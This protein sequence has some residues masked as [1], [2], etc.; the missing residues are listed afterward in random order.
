F[1]FWS[2]EGTFDS[3]YSTDLDGNKIQRILRST[4]KIKTISLDFINVKLFWIQHDTIN[5]ISYFGTS[6]YNG[7]FIKLY[8]QMERSKAYDI[9]IFGDHIY[10][11]DSRTGTIRRANKYTG[12]DIVVIN[13]KQPFPQ[14]TEILVVHPLK[15]IGKRM[16]SK[17][18]GSIESSNLNGMQRKII[19]Q[20]KVFHPQGIA[21]HPFT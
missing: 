3:I 18:L 8:R 9:F 13:L 14:S 17:G 15:Q 7:H 20:E 1:L 19:I 5:E 16:G 21:V 6:D 11:S 10:Y 2:T 4:E 12:K